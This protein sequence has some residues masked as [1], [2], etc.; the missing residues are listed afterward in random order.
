MKQRE[1]HLRTR[2]DALVGQAY[3]RYSIS[4]ETNQSCFVTPLSQQGDFQT[5]GNLVKSIKGY[6]EETKKLCDEA[7]GLSN[8]VRTIDYKLRQ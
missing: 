7:D 1:G 8:I 3:L 6:E 2:T 4:P 5:I